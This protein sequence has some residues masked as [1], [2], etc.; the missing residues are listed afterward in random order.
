MSAIGNI[1]GL[2]SNTPASSVSPA[3]GKDTDGASFLSL[4]EQALG[5]SL[6]ASSTS[7]STA[8]STASTPQAPATTLDPQAALQTFLHSLMGSLH[9]AGAAN[10]A[11]ADDS[12]SKVS[13]TKGMAADIQGLL[14]QLSAS[15]TSSTDKLGSLNANFQNLVNSI[16]AQ[17][18]SANSAAT[19]QSFLQNLYQGMGSAQSVSGTSINAKV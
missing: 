1:S 2:L 15:S 3:G 5:Q 6:A 7:S 10:D 14:Q 16:S 17:G 4:I 8:A 19:L 12:V 18:Q 11:D 9:Q 13:G